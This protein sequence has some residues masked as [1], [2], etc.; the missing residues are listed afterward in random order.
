MELLF[1]YLEG[2]VGNYK[3]L[4]S[5]WSPEI[6]GKDG[7]VKLERRFYYIDGKQVTIKTFNNEISNQEGEKKYFNIFV[8]EILTPGKIATDD[9]TLDLKQIY[10]SG[11]NI[12]LILEIDNDIII[13]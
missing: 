4:W 2:R 12:G 13:V 6:P 11:F 10:N 5:G 8:S 9:P 7:S 1:N 3:V